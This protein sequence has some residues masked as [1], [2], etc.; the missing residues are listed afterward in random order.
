MLS[1]RTAQTLVRRYAK[2]PSG[3]RRSADPRIDART[4]GSGPSVNQAARQMLS[5]WPSK[6]SQG[7]LIRR[8]A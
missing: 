8:L 4:A 7:Q 1:N 5:H 3:E 2:R 6:S